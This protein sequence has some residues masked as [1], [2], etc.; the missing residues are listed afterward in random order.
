MKDVETFNIE[1]KMMR[2]SNY[3]IFWL[4]YCTAEADILGKLVLTPTEI[5][6]EP[7]NPNFRGYYDY[8][9]RLP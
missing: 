9:G 5:V 7:L 3:P 4:Y 8:R 2:L 6:F 1:L